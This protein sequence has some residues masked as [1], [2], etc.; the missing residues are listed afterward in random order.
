MRPVLIN[1]PVAHPPSNRPAL[2]EVFMSQ[3]THHHPGLR[4]R[5]MANLPGTMAPL[6]TLEPNTLL[7]LKHDSGRARA[8]WLEETHA[9]LRHKPSSGEQTELVMQG[10]YR[11][12][13]EERRDRSCA[14][15]ARV[16]EN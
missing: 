11:P 9:G 13:T 1:V 5:A 14:V 8:C 4:L 3:V 7:L 10:R 16:G 12:I 2:G 15:P 6:L